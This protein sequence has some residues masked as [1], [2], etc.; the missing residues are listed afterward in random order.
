[1]IRRLESRD[2]EAW[3]A[4]RARLWPHADAEDLLREAYAFVEDEAA[5]FLD[6]VFIAEDDAAQPLGFLELSI[7]DF[8]DGCDSAPVPHIEGWFVEP[9]ARGQDL[10]AGLM[11][12]AE[13]WSVDHGFVELAS[14]TEVENVAS[15]NAHA[16]C[17]FEETE[18]LVKFRKVLAS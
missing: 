16:A 10:G 3:A 7:R 13:T 14:D 5:S 12:A 2:V 4:M 9:Q 11:D 15:Q 18:R 17:G 8:A 1:V 6:A